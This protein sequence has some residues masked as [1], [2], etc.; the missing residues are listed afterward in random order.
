MWNKLCVKTTLEE[1]VVA[2]PIIVLNKF[3]CFQDALGLADQVDHVEILD[4]VDPVV[5][6]EGRELQAHQEDQ[7]SQRSLFLSMLLNPTKVTLNRRL[8]RFIV[9]LVNSS[10]YNDDDS[11]LFNIFDWYSDIGIMFRFSHCFVAKSLIS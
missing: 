4:P 7:V 1:N 6:R 10:N 3:T 11:Y 5:D 2:A 8:F 9:L